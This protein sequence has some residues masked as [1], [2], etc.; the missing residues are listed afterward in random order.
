[1]AGTLTCELDGDLGDTEAGTLRLYDGAGDLKVD[2]RSQESV[3]SGAAASMYLYNGA[4][5]RTIEFDADYG[6]SHE[7]RV[8]ADVVQITGGSDLSEQF[9]VGGAGAVEPGTVVCID[10]D[11]PGSSTSPAAPTT[12]GWPAWSAGPAE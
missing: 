10:P 11:R 6:S 2:L 5:T 12:P 4:G 8:I 9:D 1:M 7:G 3:S